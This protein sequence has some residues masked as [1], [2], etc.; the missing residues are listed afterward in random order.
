LYVTPNTTE[1]THAARQ[2]S[3]GCWTSKLGKLNDIQHGTP[4]SIE[5][6]EY[7]IVYCFMKR[8]FE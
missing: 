3:N 7:G 4:E 2:L 1:C 5:G 6:T 8:K